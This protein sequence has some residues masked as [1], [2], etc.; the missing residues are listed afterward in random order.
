MAG[1]LLKAI[2]CLT[3]LLL[4][5]HMQAN[6]TPFLSEQTEISILTCSPSDRAAYTLYGHTALRIRGEIS[7]DSVRWRHIDVVF[8]YGIFDFSKPN[9]IYRFA[10]G[11]TDYMLAHETY[12]DFLMDYVMRGSEVCE[13]TLNLNPREKESLWQALLL[14]AEP[15][16]RVYRY[17][18]F[19]DNCSTRPV[20][21]LEHCLEGNLRFAET[22]TGSFRETIN[23]C[24]RRHPWL[25]FGCDLVL[26]LPTDR[27]M[28]LRESFFLPANVK[29]AFAGAHILR[30]DGGSVLLVSAQQVLV[31]TIADDGEK[32]EEE[33]TFF[34]PL[35]CS[36][37]LF[38]LVLATTLFEW[39]ARRYFRLLDC[40]LFFCA[41]A[42]GIV[43][44]F[45]CFVSV[46]PG[47]WPNLSVAWLHP[48]HWAGVVLFAVKKL[49]KA[50]YCYHLVN[51]VALLGTCMGWICLPQHVNVA[52]IPLLISLLIRSGYGIVRKI[53]N[54]G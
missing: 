29:E 37:L 31:E 54:I 19:Y 40:L 13:Q 44:F 16:N 49:N 47:I 18:F 9:F 17:N 38:A 3:G 22:E 50:A 5:L 43:L 10:K 51:F 24:T 2:G 4:A 48:F 30:P 36:L 33:E 8:N 7:L 45:L 27:Q 1:P 41:G 42:A 52:F 15:Q 11:E 46:H 25:T 12:T 21:A 6:A 34:T 32:E 35:A 26:G 14:N 20:A 23:R 39:H 53:E 28:T